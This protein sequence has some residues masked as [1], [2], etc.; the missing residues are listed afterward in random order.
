L[1]DSSFSSD[2]RDFITGKSALGRI[3][4]GI[5]ASVVRQVPSSGHTLRLTQRSMACDFS[6]IMNAGVPKD[7]IR[8]ASAA[9][10]LISELEQQM[11]VYRDDSELSLLNRRA[12]SESVIVEEELFELLCEAKRISELTGGAFDPTSGPLVTLWRICRN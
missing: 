5:D 2:R 12:A 11:S 3:R 4:E 9:L 6:V 1:S 7:R 10:D 8:D